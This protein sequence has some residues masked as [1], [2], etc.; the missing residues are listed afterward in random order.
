MLAPTTLAANG[1]GDNS[2]ARLSFRPGI[3]WQCPLD[4]M[5]EGP[6]GA[7]KLKLADR[8]LRIY[9]EQQLAFQVVANLYATCSKAKAAKPNKDLTAVAAK[10]NKI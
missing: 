3:E 2:K 5:Q 8:N 4:K 6:F 1:D 7:N 9:G 10:L